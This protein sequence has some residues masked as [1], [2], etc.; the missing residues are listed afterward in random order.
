M[1]PVVMWLSPEHR[2]APEIQ[3]TSLHPASVHSVMD[4][5]QG[6]G[7]SS[8][9]V[10]HSPAQSSS[11]SAPPPCPSCSNPV[12]FLCCYVNYFSPCYDQTQLKKGRAYFGSQFWVQSVMTGK[13]QRQEGV[14]AD[15][16]ASAVRKK[17]EMDTQPASTFLMSPYLCV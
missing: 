4:T 10:H 13:S 8:N 1:Y 12:C 6:G 11:H 3:R 16:I 17:R 7:H 5:G 15:H 2:A 9:P 14:A